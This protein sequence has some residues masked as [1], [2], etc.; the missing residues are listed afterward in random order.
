M[1]TAYLKDLRE[2]IKNNDYPGF[3]KI[4]EEWGDF[5]A[6]A[7]FF[8]AKEISKKFETFWR[9]TWPELAPLLR[10]LEVRGEYTV[11]L[12]RESF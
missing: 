10:E 1:E 5:F 8:V 4:W 12:S 9:G 6:E 11:L 3:L 2:R 7:H